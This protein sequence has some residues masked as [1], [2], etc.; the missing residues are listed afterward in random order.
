MH[1]EI[2]KKAN[3]LE[4]LFDLIFVYAVSKAAH[5]L[6]HLHEGHIGAGQYVTFILVMTL[7]WWTWTG[8]T[9][10]A[11]RFYADIW[12]AANDRPST[13]SSLFCFVGFSCS[14][15]GIHKSILML[16]KTN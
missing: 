7:I 12:M 16:S 1:N 15:S 9:L 11:T 3:W 8:H 6:A 2:I 4:L 10:F 13:F 14:I 5:I